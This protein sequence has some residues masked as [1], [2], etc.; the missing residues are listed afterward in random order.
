MDTKANINDYEEAFTGLAIPVYRFVEGEDSEHYWVDLQNCVYYTYYDEKY[1]KE[2]G[3]INGKNWWIMFPYK[4]KGV[5]ITKDNQNLIKWFVGDSS[6]TEDVDKE[7]DFDKH[8]T[9]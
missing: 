2:T 3:L 7:W 5:A 9:I 1:D 8:L 4:P 6:K